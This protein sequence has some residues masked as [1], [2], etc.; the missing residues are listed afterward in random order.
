VTKPTPEE[1][2]ASARKALA[3]VDVPEKELALLDTKGPSFDLYKDGG[4]DSLD[5]LDFAHY[6]DLDLDIKLGL[7]ELLHSDK[8]V[9]LQN[10]YDSIKQDT[11]TPA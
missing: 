6:V 11:N 7:D 5:M 1:F 3:T 2:Q 4:V 9:T 10:L 8:P